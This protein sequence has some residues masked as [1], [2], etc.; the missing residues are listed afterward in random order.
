MYVNRS[1]V[2]ILSIVGCRSIVAIADSRSF[3][4]EGWFK[5]RLGL[6][7]Y[8]LKRL[9]TQGSGIST[10]GKNMVFTASVVC[11]FICYKRRVQR[12]LRMSPL[13]F[14]MGRRFGKCWLQVTLLVADGQ[15]TGGLGV[16]STASGICFAPG[17]LL[18]LSSMVE[19]TRTTSDLF[20]RY[21]CV[22]KC[23]LAE[24]VLNARRA[25]ASVTRREGK[26]VMRKL[27]L[28]SLSRCL[29]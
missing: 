14:S 19:A 20:E 12:R 16:S 26:E 22:T 17:E 2:R 27:R 28:F 7:S 13:G 5:R 6:D 4:I 24:D 29:R 11:V 25:S 10:V 21:R 18:S 1:V 3:A 23:H 8:R 9:T 15:G